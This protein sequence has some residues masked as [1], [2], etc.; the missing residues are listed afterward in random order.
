[1]EMGFIYLPNFIY[2]TPPVVS[3]LLNVAG[4]F[5][6]AEFTQPLHQFKVMAIT[7]TFLPPSCLHNTAAFFIQ[8]V[9]MFYYSNF[10]KVPP[11]V[12]VRNK[13]TNS[14]NLASTTF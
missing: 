6:D 10:I 8:P 11:A 2:T 9:T 7:N 13:K 14:Q 3:V 12:D 4:M 1:M 5:Q